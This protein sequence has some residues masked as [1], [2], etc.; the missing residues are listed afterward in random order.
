M[1]LLDAR[2][3][4]IRD[5]LKFASIYNVHLLYIKMKSFSKEKQWK[6]FQIDIYYRDVIRSRQPAK[7]SGNFS[8][9][10]R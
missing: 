6:N 9:R 4:D 2:S 7:I 10:G 5:I 1:A 8:F 3:S